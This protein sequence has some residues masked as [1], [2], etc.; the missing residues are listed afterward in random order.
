MISD[1]AAL[2]STLQNELSTTEDTEDAEAF[3]VL[4]SVSS[5]SSVVESS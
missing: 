3:P 1:S 5:V 2:E 4:S